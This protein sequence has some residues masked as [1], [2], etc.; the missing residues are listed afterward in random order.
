[1]CIRDSCNTESGTVAKNAEYELT[2]K[3]LGWYIKLPYVPAVNSQ[4]GSERVYS[5]SELNSGRITFVSNA[6]TT[7]TTTPEP[8]ESVVGNGKHW[9]SMLDALTG[10]R[11]SKSFVNVDNDGKVTDV[12]VTDPVTGETIAP[13]SIT[14]TDTSSGITAGGGALGGNPSYLIDNSGEGPEVL[15]R[16]N[17]VRTWRQLHKFERTN[18]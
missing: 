8:C 1:M 6:P 12:T 2:A 18:D 15:G 5:D 4:E 11:L 9:L 13:T 10:K 14:R 3:Y 16:Q 17:V 7:T